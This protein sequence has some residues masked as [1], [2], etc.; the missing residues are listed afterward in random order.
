MFRDPLQERLKEM[1]LDNEIEEKNK[2]PDIAMI[3]SDDPEKENKKVDVVIVELKKLG[4]GLAKKEELLS[5]LRQR[6]RVLLNY[7]PNKIQ[8]IWFYGIIDL[9][10][11]LISSLEEIGFK[12]LF[13]SGSCY[14]G[15]LDIIPDY[16][17]RDYKI[18]TG[19]YI[20][21]Y[22]T[23]IEDAEK[24]NSTFLE[25]LKEGIKNTYCGELDDFELPDI[26]FDSK[27][28]SAGN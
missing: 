11:E 5:Q 1:E 27:E 19:F 6:A 25:I 3:F 22:S 21:S 16:N 4:L 9:N 20:M 12:E 13:S 18:P 14:Y 15:E 17:N 28:E 23:L 10:N 26:I 2:R 8:R 7:Y 24:R